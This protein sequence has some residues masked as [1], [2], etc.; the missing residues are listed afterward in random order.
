MASR[1]LL[2][3]RR[4]QALVT[5]IVH[6][7][8]KR[9]AA[10]SLASSSSSFTKPAVIVAS[11]HDSNASSSSLP[12]TAFYAAAALT[13]AAWIQSQQDTPCSTAAATAWDPTIRTKPTPQPRNVMLHRMRSVRGRNLEDKY[14]VDWDTVL[15]EGAYGSVHPARLAATGEKVSHSFSHRAWFS[16]DR[17]FIL[18]S[19]ARQNPFFPHHAC[20]TFST[21][22]NSVT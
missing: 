12:L 13:G 21:C 10:R 17:I 2:L 4:R 5:S 1:T 6:R 3:L 20:S 9:Q 11:Q 7:T 15:G 8:V 14:N 22:R 19:G 16:P 18:H